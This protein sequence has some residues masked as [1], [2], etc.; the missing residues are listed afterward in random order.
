MTCD[1]VQ[2]PRNVL[3]VGGSGGIGRELVE[4]FCA[5]DDVAKVVATWNR[6]EPSYRHAKLDWRE[7]DVTREESLA[8]CWPLEEALDVLVYA[9]G[10]LHTQTQQPEKTIRHLDPELFM[11]SMRVNALPALILA[12]VLHPAFKRSAAPR[13]AAIS[14]RVGSIGEN[15]KG[16]WYSY[17]CSKA[18]LNMALRTLS[19][20]W[21]IAM[22]RGSVALLHPGT[23]DTSLSKPFQRGVSP[24]KLFPARES[25]R[26][27]MANLDRLDPTNSGHFWS[28]DGSQLPW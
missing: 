3:V 12:Q 4:L 10:V 16:G 21:R 19:V 24:E 18:A 17:R 25:A 23:A 8:A 2:T 28:W 1:P 26:R 13:F 22:P 6:Q 20:E 15:Q 9:V 27:L 11:Y 14:A 5:R 7:L